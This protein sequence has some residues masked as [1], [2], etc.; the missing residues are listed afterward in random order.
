VPP[1]GPMRDRERSVNLVRANPDLRLA[2]QGGDVFAGIRKQSHP[3]DGYLP[4]ELIIQLMI[5]LSRSGKCEAKCAVPATF[6]G[7]VELL[8]VRVL[9]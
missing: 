2:G 8:S 4:F 6:H 1:L 9:R 7:T 5:V 3:L